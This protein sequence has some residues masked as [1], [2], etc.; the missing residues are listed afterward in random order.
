MLKN[1]ACVVCR[2]LIVF[3]LAI[4]VLTPDKTKSGEYTNLWKYWTD[5]AY[6]TSNF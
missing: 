3:M 4:L 2:L 6:F 1:V 5:D